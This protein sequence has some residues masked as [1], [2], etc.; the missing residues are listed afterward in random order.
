MTCV[1][2]A[3]GAPGRDGAK[4]DLGSREKLGPKD[5]VALTERKEPREN[6]GSGVPPDKK[7]NEGERAS[8]E[9]L[10]TRTGRIVFGKTMTIKIQE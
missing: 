4:G 2:G 10:H 6:L 8:V 5:H 3:P 7:E 9:L 1:P